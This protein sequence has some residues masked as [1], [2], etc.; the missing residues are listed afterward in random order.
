VLALPLVT[1]CNV[2]GGSCLV[3]VTSTTHTGNLGGLDGADDI[4]QARA[5]A[6][7]RP[8]TFKAW[9]SDSTASAMDR[10]THANVPYVRVDDVQVADDW[11]DL[12]DG[13][14][15]API[16]KDEAN[17]TTDEFVWTGTDGRGNEVT[18]N[19]A[20]WTSRDRLLVGVVGLSRFADSWT[21]ATTVDCRTSLSLYCFEQ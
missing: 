16:V 12:V 19:C 21:S 2:P 11:V 10:L 6:A 8:G 18:P 5:A 20:G 3:F 15:D 4:C 1:T 17:V 14:L 13:T 7:G 9:L